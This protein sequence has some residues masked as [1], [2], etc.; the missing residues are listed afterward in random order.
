MDQPRVA[1]AFALFW[2]AASSGS[3]FA[4]DV[5][6]FAD[7]ADDAI[8]DADASIAVMF[9]PLAIACGVFGGEADF[10][11][12]RSLAI[13]LDAVGYRPDAA[14]L[15]AVGAGLLIYPLRSAFHGL[16][17]EP[18]VTYTRALSQAV[19]SGPG[20]LVVAGLSGWQWTWDYGLSIR[21]GVGVAGSTGGLAVRAPE[22]SVGRLALIADAGV[23]WAW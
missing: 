14:T 5:P 18:R 1:I 15:G 21:L 8:E 22:F 20:A 4:D 17:L 16:Y 12:Q 3:A 13:S 6:T 19:V 10:V 2:V 11:V 9:D 7:R 23:G